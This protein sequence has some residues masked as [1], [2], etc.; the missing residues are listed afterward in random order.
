[1]LYLPES[2]MAPLLTTALPHKLTC[3]F[4]PVALSAMAQGPEDL[5][6]QL[7]FVGLVAAAALVDC[8]H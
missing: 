8:L 4:P 7:I 5:V 1:M 6:L 2:Y 3:L